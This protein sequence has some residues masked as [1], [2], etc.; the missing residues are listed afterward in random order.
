MEKVVRAMQVQIDYVLKGALNEDDVDEVKKK[1]LLTEATR[2]ERNSDIAEYY[3]DMRHVT[4]SNGG[5]RSYSDE[6]ARVTAADLI[7][8]AKK[9]MQKEQGVILKVSP[10]L[11]YEQLG[12]W[13]G[14]SVLLGL[15]WPVHRWQRRRQGKRMGHR[16]RTDK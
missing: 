5:L 6:I 11:T 14:G 12:L 7:R 8:I 1:L 13:T 16:R 3:V 4:P 15:C 2:Y 10:T 9:Y